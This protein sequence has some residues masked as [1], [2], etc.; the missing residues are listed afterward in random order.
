MEAAGSHGALMAPW[1]AVLELPNPRRS[2]MNWTNLLNWF[3]AGI[4]FAL[5]NWLLGKI[6]K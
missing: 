3:V 2:I 6:L 5:G 1:A 4:G